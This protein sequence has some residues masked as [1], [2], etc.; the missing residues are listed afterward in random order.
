MQG[1]RLKW[2]LCGVVAIYCSASIASVL[3]A[4]TSYPQRPI[5]FVIPQSPGG[6]SDTV[7][8]VVAHK[9]SEYLGQQL[10][11]D[12]RPGATGN[13]GAELVKDAPADGYTILLTAAN[14]VTSSGLYL[15][16]PFD[17]VRDFAPVSQLAQSP[18]VWIV[19]P[20]FAARTMKELIDMAKG[21]PGEINY[22]SSGLASTQHLAGE[23]LNFMAGI[24]LVHIPYKGGG[25]ALIDLMGGRVPVMSSSL[26]SAVPHIKSG[27]VRAL[28]VTS[29]K[30]SSATPDLPTV[31]EAAGFPA[32]EAV[33]WQGLVFPAAVQ[34][35]IIERISGETIKVLALNEVKDRLLVLGYEPVGSTPAQFATFISAELRKWP[36]I[37]KAA[38]IKAE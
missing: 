34:R 36:K 17:P 13:V 35:P 18:N 21:K 5:R 1:T 2:W 9:L 23:L 24:K 14:L 27:K 3:A 33:T 15:R 11:I 8:R 16:V 30:R 19:H 22:S 12:N 26:P 32:Y 4:E 38:G 29:A 10:V 6:A 31:A 28:A 7:G 20:S 25:P 37:I